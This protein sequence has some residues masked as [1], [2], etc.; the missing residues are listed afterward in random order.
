MSGVVPYKTSVANTLVRIEPTDD[1]TD[2]Y[3]E[4]ISDHIADLVMDFAEKYKKIKASEL[5]Y[6]ML[7]L[8]ASR[9]Y[10]G[11]LFE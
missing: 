8:G 6:D 1:Y 3:T 5:M 4:L 11:Q 7:S 9:S 10:A 2:K